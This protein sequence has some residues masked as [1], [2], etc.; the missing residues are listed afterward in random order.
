MKKTLNEE[1]AAGRKL[2]EVLIGHFR[3]SC[4]SLTVCDP[5][6]MDDEI[7]RV[8]NVLNGDWQ[9]L[10]STKNELPYGNCVAFLIAETKGGKPA[11]PWERQHFKVPIEAGMASIGDTDAFVAVADTDGWLN[12]CLKLT[13]RRSQAGIFEGGIVSSSGYGDGY[14]ACYAR[15]DEDG[16]VVSVMLD[17]DLAWGRK[18]MDAI[19]RR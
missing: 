1:N 7:R 4:G 3:V 14:Y 6:A 2:A 8:D 9:G 10:V 18:M 15:R 5:S 11:T 12:R 19:C 16:K 17:F 13:D